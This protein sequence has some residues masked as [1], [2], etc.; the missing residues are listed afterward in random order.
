MDQSNKPSPRK[1]N[2]NFTSNIDNLTFIERLEK[3]E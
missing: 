2:T 1:Y 3:L